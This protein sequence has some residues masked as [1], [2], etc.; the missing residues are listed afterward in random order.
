MSYQVDTN[1][2]LRGVQTEHPMHE[3]A[4]QAIQRLLVAGEILYYLP[5]NIREFWNV[6]TRPTERNGLETV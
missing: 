6:C 5:Q 2:L 4:K 1:I 3:T